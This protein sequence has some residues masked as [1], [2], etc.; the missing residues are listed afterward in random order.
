MNTPDVSNYLSEREAKERACC[1][2]QAY[3]DNEKR[4]VTPA[5]LASKCM[6]WI[7]VETGRYQLDGSHIK[8]YCGF[9][10]IRK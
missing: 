1:K 4:L 10:N 5:C 8:G 3:Y 6:A 7:A 2:Q 9:V